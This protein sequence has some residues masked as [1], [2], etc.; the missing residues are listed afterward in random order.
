MGTTTIVLADDHPIV[1]RGLRAL[2]EADGACTVV[3]EAGD[4]LEAVRLVEQLRPMVLLVDLSLPTMPGLHV[5]REVHEKVPAT[6]IIAHTMHA[7]AE[8]LQAAL[9]NGAV[10]YVLKNASPTELAEAIRSVVAGRRFLSAPLAVIAVQDFVAGFSPD[11]DDLHNTLTDR[12]REV[13]YLAAEG[14]TNAGIGE[15]LGISAR[16]VETH[17]SNLMRK[18]HLRDLTD[19]VRYAVRRGLVPPEQPPSR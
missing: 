16:T 6:R 4:G 17:R 7:D 19:L 13:L 18:L 12:E 3:G 14:N 2:L 9:R 15:K 11:E 1:R 10:G 8:H 5:I